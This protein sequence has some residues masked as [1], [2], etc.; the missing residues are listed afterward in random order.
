MSYTYFSFDS[1]HISQ[2]ISCPSTADLML[3][4]PFHVHHKDVRSNDASNGSKI[5]IL[6]IITCITL[7]PRHSEAEGY[8]N[9][10]VGLARVWGTIT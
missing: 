6:D 8:R 2:G 3:N 1:T 10:G 5:G 4:T 9:Q 7:I